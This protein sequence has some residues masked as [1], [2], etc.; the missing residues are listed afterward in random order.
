MAYTGKVNNITSSQ[1]VVQ[2]MQPIK[3]IYGS[4][5]EIRHGQDGASRLSGIAG[6]ANAI[7]AM[8][9]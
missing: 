6:L 1:K 2:Q 9:G 7:M 4:L 5:S 3:D 8:M